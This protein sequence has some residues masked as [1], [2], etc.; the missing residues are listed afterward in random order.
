MINSYL[1]NILFI[2]LKILLI[3]KFWTLN[4][5]MVNMIPNFIK[6]DIMKLNPRKKRNQYLM[7]DIQK[8]YLKLKIKI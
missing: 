1:Y 3:L 8:F 6:V 7:F 2:K 4:N 5:L